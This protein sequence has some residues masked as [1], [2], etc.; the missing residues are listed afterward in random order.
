MLGIRLDPETERGLQSLVRQTGRPKSQI[1]REAIQQYIAK[2]DGLE[3][4]RMQ[5]AKI[6]EAERDDP[7]M[8]AILEAAM[9]ELDPDL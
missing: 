8:N 6:S 4:A 2:N 7:E 9:R 5:W 3:R 1:A